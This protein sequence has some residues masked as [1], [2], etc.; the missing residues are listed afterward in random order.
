MTREEVEWSFPSWF[1]SKTWPVYA[2]VMVTTVWI[3][4]VWP[5]AYGCAAILGIFIFRH[6]LGQRVIQEVD[7]TFEQHETLLFID[8]YTQI[9][10]HVSG[11]DRFCA[12]GI[13]LSVQLNTR[14]LLVAETA[15]PVTIRLTRDATYYI[16]AHAKVRGPAQIESCVLRLALPFR[17]GTLFFTKSMQLPQFTVLP[18]ISRYPAVSFK[19]IRMG[20]RVVR[21]SPLHDPL[22][23]Q[24]AKRYEQEPVKQIDWVATSKTGKLQAKVFQRQ[25]LDTFTLVLD[26]SGPLGNGLHARY[27]ELIQQTAY[28]VSYLVKEDCKVELFINRLDADN[29]IDHLRMSDGRKQLRLALIR[30][31]WIYE[32]DRFVASKRFNQII[33]RQK[34]PHAEVIRI[35]VSLLNR[36]AVG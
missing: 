19:Q 8:D 24:S 12:L 33:D 34:H 29:Q 2:C 9:Q 32:S 6:H 26:L 4:Y 36:M 13:P 25:N 28:L 17:I 18:S 22:L 16:D 20:D 21:H 15:T 3:P 27:E 7:L 14:G 30:L 31:A 5:L 1:D 10:M 11:I 35:D 23:V